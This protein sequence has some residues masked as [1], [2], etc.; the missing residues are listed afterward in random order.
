M[1]MSHCETLRKITALADAQHGVVSVGQQLALGAEARFFRW[2]RRAGVMERVTTR[3]DRVAGS[4]RSPLQLA[5]AAILHA[6]GLAAV[7]HES[8]AAVHSYTGYRLDI[9]LVHIV[10]PMGR[11]KPVIEGV[12]V[13]RSRRLTASDICVIGGI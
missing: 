5:Q 8:A 2:A 11:A 7:S 9:G 6:G 1:D 10:I 3:V 12:I 4:T 13:H